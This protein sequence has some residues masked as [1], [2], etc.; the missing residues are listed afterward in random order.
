M[1]ANQF[2][3]DLDEP[4]GADTA[5]DIDRQALACMLVD[6]REALQLLTI[7][8]GVKHKVVSPHLVRRERW[9]WSRPGARHTSPRPFSRHLQPG[10]APQSVRSIRT[11]LLTPS[12]E[13]YVDA[14]IPVPGILARE[15][16]HHR[17][18]RAVLR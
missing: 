14:S 18:Y 16:P 5:S 1:L 3:Q 15:L 7:G 4:S 9:K 17:H 6:H 10:E 8:A 2:R 11:H 13:K 12:G